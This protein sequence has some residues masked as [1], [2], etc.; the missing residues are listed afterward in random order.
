MTHKIKKK[1]EIMPK[2]VVWDGDLESTYPSKQ[3]QIVTAMI[4]QLA[5]KKITED[6][7]CE[8]CKALPEFDGDAVI[9]M[10]WYGKPLETSLLHM[11]VI[12]NMHRFADFLVSK[13]ANPLRSTSG[14]EYCWR[15]MENG[16]WEFE[17]PLLHHIENDATTTP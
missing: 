1:K 8:Y 9:K 12:F 4:Q 17:L 3:I 5:C 10:K 16:K 13:N 2:V 6:E 7:L 14:G 15:R 11:A